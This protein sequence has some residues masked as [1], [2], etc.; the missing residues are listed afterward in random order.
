MK[1]AI[2][3]FSKEEFNAEYLHKKALISGSGHGDGMFVPLLK[4][5]LIRY[6]R[7]ND[8]MLHDDIKADTIGLICVG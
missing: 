7:A 4:D 1:Q 3:H 5:W 8:L 2:Q 6:D